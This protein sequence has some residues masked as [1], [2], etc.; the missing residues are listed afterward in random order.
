M[1]TTARRALAVGAAAVTIALTS[2]AFWLSYAHLHTIAASNGLAADT[3]RAWAWPATV[4]LF[5]VAGELLILRASLAHR[6]DPWAIS[7]T[8]LGSGGSIALNVA[9]VGT[10]AAALE[11]IVAAVPPVAAL[12][13]FGA[14]MRQV[15]EVLAAT[16]VPVDAPEAEPAEEAVPDAAPATPTQLPQP[17]AAVPGDAQFLPIVSNRPAP[18]TPRRQPTPEVV[19]PGARLLKIVPPVTE[20]APEIA[21]HSAPPP[22]EDDLTA[23][24][25]WDYAGD[26]AAGEMPSIRSLRAAYSI[27]QTRA[28]RIQG[29]LADDLVLTLAAAGAGR[30]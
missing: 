17:P 21:D 9:G 29:E 19:P 27:G 8:V 2:A 10:G 30:G 13:A 11:Y 7:L 26:L 15:H 3:A 20:Y 18:A 5:I 25:R 24:A 12:L 1:H 22:A 6:V 28:Q 14:V 23:T 16:P 4:D